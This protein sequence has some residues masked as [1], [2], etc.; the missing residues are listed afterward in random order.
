MANQTGQTGG[1]TLGGPVP[2]VRKTNWAVPTRA[3]R[4]S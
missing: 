4:M 2:R 1:D 3:R